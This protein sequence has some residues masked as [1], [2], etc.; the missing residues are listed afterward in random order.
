M[1]IGI[2]GSGRMARALG[3]AFGRA[4]HTVRLGSATPRHTSDDGGAAAH[5]VV[6]Y[7]AATEHADVVV[8]ASL[9]EA[10]PGILDAVPALG[11]RILLDCSNP[12]APDG[13]S[14]VIGHVTSGAERVQ[15]LAPQARVVKAFN[16]VYAEVL[17]SGPVFAGHR[18]SVMCCSDYADAKAVVMALAAGCGFD[19]V[20]AG[21]LRSARFLEPVAAL[22]IELV[23]GQGLAPGDVALALLRR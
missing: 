17:D 3:A 12:E 23:R 10:I 2:L 20:D 8:L 15:A 18:A 11:A 7:A 13:R 19:P 16:H 6:S 9:W 4:G 14:L 22:M 5:E 1:H 21:P